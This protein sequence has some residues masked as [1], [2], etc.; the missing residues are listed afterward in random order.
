MTGR[1]NESAATGILRTP[2]DHVEHFDENR[3]H[4]DMQTL[5]QEHAND[6]ARR[7]RL[8]HAGFKGRAA[9]GARAENVAMGHAGEAETLA[10][11]RGSSRH[12]ANMRRGGCKAVARAQSASG[13]YY[14]A[15]VIGR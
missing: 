15:M 5:A 9:R 3:L 13:R 1:W 14:W 12:A 4:G 7:D 6:M 10:Q 2:T 8:D 11:W